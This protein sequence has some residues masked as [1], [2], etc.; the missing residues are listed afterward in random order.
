MSDDIR[1]VVYYSNNDLGSRRNLE[2]AEKIIQLF[3][4]NNSFTIND[5]LELYNIQLYF[6]NNLRLPTWSDEQYQ[7]YKTITSNFWEL[8]KSFFL[9]IDNSNFTQI[10]T[11]INFQYTHN[12]LELFNKLNVFK[13]VDSSLISALLVSKKYIFQELLYNQELVNYYSKEIVEH[14]EKNPETAEI[15]LSHF[16]EISFSEKKKIYIPKIFSFDKIET[17]INRYI[18]LPEPN[19]NYI[20]LIVNSQ[21]LKLD[22]KTKFRASKKEREITKSFFKENNGISYGVEIGISGEQSEPKTLK[23]DEVNNRLIYTYS[24]NYLDNARDFF[25]IFKNFT[26][27]FEYANFQGCM[28]LVQRNCEMGT[29]DKIFM[30]SKG[31]F[32]KYIKFNQKE[33]LS[34]GQFAI[35]KHYLRNNNVDIEDVISFVV[36]ETL[37]KVYGIEKLKISLPSKETEF[38]EKVRILAPELEFL[39][40]Q[41]NA[42]I[43]DGKIDFEL[44]RFNSSPIY[45]SKLKSKVEIKYVYPKGENIYRIKNG[46]FSTQS[47]LTYIDPFKNKYSHLY[48]LLLKE[49]IT[50]DLFEGFQQREIDYLLE[51]K[52]IFFDINNFIRVDQIM[53]LIFSLFHYQEVIS[54]WH[55]PLEMRNILIEFEKQNEVIFEN[56]LFTREEIRYLNYNLNKKEFSNGLDLRNKYI[57]GSNSESKDVQENDYNVLLKILILILIKIQDDILI[58]KVEN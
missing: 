3:D 5:L 57:H 6:K 36:V 26:F 37:Q 29:M 44:L 41:Y 10:F 40:K 7:K 13:K 34:N 25:S 38:F 31:E 4:K 15:I 32:L 58:S 51:K 56:C 47:S 49:N 20:N 43:E 22:F 50:Y 16:E 30:R 19:L 48:E 18:S 45:F 27:L 11:E 35:Y 33:L 8:I 55:F 1:R 53:S 54:F 39:L 14:F 17:L 9:S 2:N 28:N 46:L 42:F 12:F 24:R 21:N 52:I 23:H